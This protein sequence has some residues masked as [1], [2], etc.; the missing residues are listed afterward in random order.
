MYINGPETRRCPNAI[1]ERLTRLFGKNQFGDPHWKIV[2]SQS[3]FIRLGN[4]WFDKD[5]TERRGYRETYVAGK[6]PCWVIMRWHSPEEYGSPRTYYS[7]TFDELTQLHY[8][9]EYPW[10]GRY[11]VVQ[12]LI[13]KEIRNGRLEISHFPISHYL[14]DTIIPMMIAYQRLSLEQKKA[15]REI[16][17]AAEEKAE[18]ER[19][20][21]ILEDNMPKWWGPVSFSRQGIRTSLLD[22]KMEQIKKVWDQMSHRGRAPRF[23]RGMALGDKPA[24]IN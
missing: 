19:I 20:A 23:S 17:R 7:S 10:R 9:G 2:W 24:Q 15:A 14:V 5:G 3:A 12:P 18:T 8:V 22:R 6:A 21:D 11:E 4:C 16:A 1:Q 13:S